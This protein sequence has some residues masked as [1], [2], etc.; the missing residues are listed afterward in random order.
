MAALTPA[1][2]QLQFSLDLPAPL[3]NHQS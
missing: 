1:S 3:I 2:G